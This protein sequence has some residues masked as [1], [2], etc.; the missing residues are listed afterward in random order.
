VILR[1]ASQMSLVAA[2]TEVNQADLA[3]M[4]RMDEMNPKT[5]AAW[6]LTEAYAGPH[7]FLGSGFYDDLGNL[8]KGL[9]TFASNWFEVQAVADLFVATPFAMTSLLNQYGPSL[10]LLRNQVESAESTSKQ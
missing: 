10:D 5:G 9:S 2:S 6:T 4:R 1:N 7:D 8:K 3:L